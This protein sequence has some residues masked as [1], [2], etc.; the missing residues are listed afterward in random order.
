MNA[1]NLAPAHLG[2][3]AASM[4]PLQLPITAFSQ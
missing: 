4:L 2:R 3:K 1:D